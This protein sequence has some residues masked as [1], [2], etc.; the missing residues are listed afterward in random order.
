MKVL[1]SPYFW[2]MA[3]V[4]AYCGVAVI[5]ACF[6]DPSVWSVKGVIVCFGIAMVSFFGG[7]ALLMIKKG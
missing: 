1:R 6:G 4:P 5:W 3:A 7:L 2:L